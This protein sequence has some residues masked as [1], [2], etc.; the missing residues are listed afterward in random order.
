MEKGTR[1]KITKATTGIKRFLCDDSQRFGLHKTGIQNNM[2]K[3]NCVFLLT[4]NT[5]TWLIQRI[6]WDVCNDELI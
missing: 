2:T 1:L 3:I 5:E 6:P 4:H